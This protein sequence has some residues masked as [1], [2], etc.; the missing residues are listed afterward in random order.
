[1]LYKTILGKT[2]QLT[3]ERKGHILAK[4]PELKPYF[5]KI[6]SVL[7]KPEEIRKS[8]R[9]RQ[10]LLF[11]RHFAK[12]LGGKYIVVLARFNERNFILTSYITDKIMAG[13]HYEKES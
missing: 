12:I 6:K 10:V 9:D 2:A 13:D 4:H 1:M 8:K 5:V 11:Y 3:E 7:L